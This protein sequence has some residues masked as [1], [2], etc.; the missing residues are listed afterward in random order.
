MQRIVLLAVLLFSGSAFADGCDYV[1]GTWR[2]DRYDEELQSQIEIELIFS[3]QGGLYAV[4]H[5]NDGSDSHYY[6][7]WGRW[8]CDNDVIEVSWSGNIYG[9]EDESVVYLELQEANSSYLAF[10]EIREDS[11]LPADRQAIRVSDSTDFHGC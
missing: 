4:S 7:D 1:E 3:D 8:S 10:R 6:E 9:L 11:D 5:A 2:I